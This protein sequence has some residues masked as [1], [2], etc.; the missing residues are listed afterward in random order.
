MS[1]CTRNHFLPHHESKTVNDR[2]GTKR[3]AFEN[4]IVS[5]IFSEKEK[6]NRRYRYSRLT[7]STALITFP[8]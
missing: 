2:W 5:I 3:K 8:L 6:G 1:I 7:V 4:N